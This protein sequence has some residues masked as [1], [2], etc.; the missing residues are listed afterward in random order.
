VATE[1]EVVRALGPKS[2]DPVFFA[3]EVLGIRLNPAQ[4]R[5]VRL[6][7]VAPDGWSWLYRRVVHVA[8]NQIGKTLGL[9]FL[10]LWAAHCKMGQPNADWDTWLSNPFRWYHLAPSHPQALLTM[11]DMAALMEGAHPAQIDRETGKRRPFLW[12][13]SMFEEIKF[14]A[15]YPGFRLWNGSEIHFRTS[16]EKAQALQGVV[17]HGV[18][19]DEAAFEFYLLHILNQAVKLRLISTGGPIWM[20]STPDGINDYYEVVTSVQNGGINTSERVWEWPQR[21]MAL[22]WSHISD[23]VGFGLTQEEVDFLEEDVDPA[24]KE[25]QLRGAF[26]APQD[27][28]FVPQDRIIEAWDTRLPEEQKPKNG[29]TYA[30]FWDPSVSADPTVLIILDI[31]RKPYQGVYFQ[32]WQTP[33]GIHELLMEIKRVHVKWNTYDPRKPGLRPQATTGFDSTSMGGVIIKQELAGIIPKRPVNFGGKVKINALTNTRAALSRK[34]IILPAT[35][36]RVQRE[37]LGYRLLDT[38]IVQD[39]VMAL[40]GASFLAAIRAS[41]KTSQPFDT[42]Y[43]AFGQGRR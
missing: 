15:A 42:S 5:W 2:R 20:V 19:I 7:G 10:I 3:E 29:H 28:F 35:W 6:C 18:S 34:D 33:M 8:A 24:T 21:K 9:A 38:K 32:R 11:K 12:A 22:V 41:G 16:A 31:T 36:L 39:C 25:Q 17:A 27:A 4:K 30:I 1:E 14:D 23:N 43:R 26:I 13:S 40:A 37:V